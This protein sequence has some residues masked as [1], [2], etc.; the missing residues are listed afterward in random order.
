M[1]HDRGGVRVDTWREVL[2]ASAAVYARVALENIE[3]EFPSDVWQRMDGPDDL[4]K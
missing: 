4:P 2:R 1:A 3:R